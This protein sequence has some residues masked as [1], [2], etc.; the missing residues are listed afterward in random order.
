MPMWA[1]IEVNAR[2]HEGKQ[3]KLMWKKALCDIIDARKTIFKRCHYLKPFVPP[4]VHGK[5]WWDADT[6]TIATDLAYWKFDPEENWHG[7]KGYDKD[8]YV[9][10]P[11]KLQLITPGINVEDDSFEDFG[12]NA[13]ILFAFLRENNI[14]PEKTSLYSLLFLITPAETKVKLDNLIAQLVRFERLVD[15]DAPLYEVL[16]TTYK[17]Y[18][19]QY[20]DYTIRQLCQEMHD[21]YKSNNVKELQKQLFM[22]DYLPEQGISAQQAHN[23]LVRND[24]EL[25]PL[26]Q[27]EGR[28]ALDDALP[29]PPGVVCVMSGER[30]SKTATKYFQTLVDGINALPGFAPEIQGVVMGT[31]KDGKAMAS[32]Y[33]LKKE[34]EDEYKAEYVTERVND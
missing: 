12:I 4:V 16:P 27:I 9:V 31:D 11:M 6:E 5:P 13:T 20:R 29:Y 24:G 8:Q 34:L 25:V 33:V 3:G 32:G 15:E 19:A 28:I 1:S 23:A 10:D 18:F 30:W 7:Y 22:K 21:F 14:T 17:Q 2:M 26:S